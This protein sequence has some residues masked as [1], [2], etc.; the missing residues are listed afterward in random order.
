MKY[1]EFEL[2]GSSFKCDKNCPYCTAK[3]TKWP[4]VNDKF[5]LLE[6]RLNYLKDNGI[7]FRYFIFCGNGEPSLLSYDDFKTVV[8]ATR[9]VNIFDKKRLQSSG[10]IFYE[11]KKLELIKNDFMV[12]ITRVSMDSQKDMEILGYKRDYINSANFSKVPVRLNYVLLKNRSIEES[13]EEIKAYIK[14]YPNIKTVSLKTLNLNT[15]NDEI[16]NPYSKWIIK[17]ALTKKDSDDIIKF[18]TN[19]TKFVVSDEKFFD[20]YEW[21]FE[22]VPITFYAKK[23]DYGYSNIVYYGG[24]LVDYHLNDIKIKSKEELE[25][26]NKY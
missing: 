5:E 14:K 19:N 25:S 11:D 20:R 22:G 2:I 26:S 4:N 13:L 17:H 16:N 12:E 18:M 23:L 15:K 24:K 6:D 3:I 10:N 9:K 21:V 7:S 8:E 1:K